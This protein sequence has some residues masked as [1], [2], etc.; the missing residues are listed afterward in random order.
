MMERP[1]VSIEEFEGEMVEAARDEVAEAE[2]AEE[3]EEAPA[4]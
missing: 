1:Y 2:E 4:P 3:A